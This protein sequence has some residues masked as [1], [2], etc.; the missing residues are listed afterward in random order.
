M[1]LIFV[2]FIIILI[3]F[4]LY[5]TFDIDQQTKITLETEK[6]YERMKIHVEEKIPEGAKP[7]ESKRLPDVLIIGVK[8]S[9]T[10][11]LGRRS[12]RCSFKSYF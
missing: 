5:Y 2:T 11:T 3:F 4:A 7:E 8:K 1:N 6:P 12:R 9:G 10:M